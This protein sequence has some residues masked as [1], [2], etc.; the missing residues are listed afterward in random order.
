MRQDCGDTAFNSRSDKPRELQK[1]LA[2]GARKIEF[3][4]AIQSDLPCLS[5]F[6]SPCHF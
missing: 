4:D 3:V 6:T 1:P 2:S 5:L